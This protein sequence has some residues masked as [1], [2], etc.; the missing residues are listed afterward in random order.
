MSMQSPAL[1]H[2]SWE[3]VAGLLRPFIARRVAAP[4]DADDVLQEVLIRVHRGLSG[5]RDEEQVAAWMYRI[6][7]NAV[8]DHLRSRPREMP[9]IELESAEPSAMED[10]DAA[11]VMA[12]ALSFFIVELPSPYREAITLTELE[13]R[14]Q[15]EAAEMLGIKVSTM[16]SRVQRGRAKLRAMLEACCEIALDARGRVMTCAP[17]PNGKVPSGCRC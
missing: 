7:R 11:H 5:L 2:R 3:S 13:G 1:D 14:T 9:A 12:R 6:A 16:K 15:R 4:E 8:I 10:D 17:R